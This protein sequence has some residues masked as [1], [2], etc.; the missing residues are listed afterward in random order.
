[1]PERI[2]KNHEMV[3]TDRLRREA[4][5]DRPAFSQ[6]L[7]ERICH[8]VR[9]SGG[10]VI[11]AERPR[12]VRAWAVG[13]AAIG[14]AACLV[15]AGFV[16]RNALSPPSVPAPGDLAGAEIAQPPE[17]EEAQ[18]PELP[19]VPRLASS[20]PD[21]PSLVDSAKNVPKWAYLDH[22]ARLAVE[23]M[24]SRFPFD[25]ASALWAR[26]AAKTP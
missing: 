26:D 12:G 23:T 1:M 19:G 7:H 25:L 13:L 6:I 11:R 10:T 20:M 9:L 22:D 16:L 2:T 15:I 24:A 14:A 18:P 17:P 5:E 4:F 8:A 3:L 21:L